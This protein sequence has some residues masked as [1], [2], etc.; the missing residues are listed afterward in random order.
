MEKTNV[1]QRCEILGKNDIL[2]SLY[3]VNDSKVVT[4]D[5]KRLLCIFFRYAFY[6]WFSEQKNNR[7]LLR[8]NGFSTQ[9]RTC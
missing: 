8:D 2:N 1:Q 4:V 5:T 6:T 7:K 9:E 3:R